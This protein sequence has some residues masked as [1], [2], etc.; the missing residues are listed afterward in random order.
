MDSW[1]WKFAVDGLLACFLLISWMGLVA[2]TIYTTG[3][4]IGI[5]PLSRCT[6]FV[7]IVHPLPE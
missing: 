3:N 4:D 6:E 5:S 2:Q 7:Q 1:P